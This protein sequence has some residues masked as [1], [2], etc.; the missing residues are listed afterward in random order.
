MRATGR[1]PLYA[2]GKSTR[3]DAEMSE[4]SADDKASKPEDLRVFLV[5]GIPIFIITV[6]LAALVVFLGPNRGL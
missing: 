6:S 5:L 4:A 3:E 1:R 2:G